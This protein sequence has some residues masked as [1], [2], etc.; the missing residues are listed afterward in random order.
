MRLVRRNDLEDGGMF[1]EEW[2]SSVADFQVPYR[3][4]ISRMVIKRILLSDTSVGIRI[5]MAVN[6]ATYIN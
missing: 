3:I 5:V 6:T 2:E 1:L 4:K